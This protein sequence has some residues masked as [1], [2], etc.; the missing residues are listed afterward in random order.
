MSLIDIS[1]I[2]PMSLYIVFTD[3][4]EENKDDRGR[5]ST[6]GD[7]KPKIRKMGFMRTG[8]SVQE[9]DMVDLRVIAAMPVGGRYGSTKWM[10]AYPASI[11]LKELLSGPPLPQLGL[12]R[13]FIFKPYTA[14]QYNTNPYDEADLRFCNKFM[15]EIYL[16]RRWESNTTLEEIIS[17]AVDTAVLGRRS[18][19]WE[20]LEI[21]KQVLLYTRTASPGEVAP[22]QSVL[23][24]TESTGETFYKAYY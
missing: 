24:E 9:D 3:F 6:R 18:Y 11:E 17:M 7:E 16:N 19:Y 15:G 22:I 4:D 5:R 20:P 1:Q 13:D 14:V 10:L 12:G 8:D 21:A 2:E 23:K